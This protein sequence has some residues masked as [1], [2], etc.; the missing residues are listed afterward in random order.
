MKFKLDKLCE[1]LHIYSVKVLVY[2]CLVLF[3]V[4][5]LSNFFI[6]T[7]FSETYAE[8]SLFRADN[9]VIISAL[10]AVT[11]FLFLVIDNKFS[12]SKLKVW[13]LLFL[14]MVF[15]LLVS[16]IWVKIA[17]STP[18][19]D[20]LFVSMIASD[21]LKGDYTALN[22]GNYLY[23][24]PFQ[25]GIVA[26]IELVYKIAGNGNYQAIQYLNA[27]A[28]CITFF[29]LYRIT[30]LIFGEKI[31]KVILMLLFGCFCAM[32]FCTYVYGNLFGLAF[33]SLALWMELAYLESNKSKY[34]IMSIIFISIG[35]I[36]KNN[37]SIVLIAMVILLIINFLKKKD[38]L[39]IIFAVLMISST[40]ATSNALKTYYSNRAHV[41]VNEGIPMVTFVAMGLQDGWFGKG[42]YNKYTVDTYKLAKYNEKETTKI[43]NEK[44][45]EQ[46]SYYLKNP[47]IGL[48]FFAEKSTL[49]W[50]EPTYM[51]IWE[52][53][54]ANNHNHELSNFTN[55][56]YVGFW[57]NLIVGFMNFYQSF[58]WICAAFYIILK[59]K[60]LNENQ[61]LLGLIII[62]GFLFHIMWEAKSQYIIQYF[63]FAIP[64][65][66]AGFIEIL[67]KS[68]EYLQKRYEISKIRSQR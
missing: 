27:I 25:L 52:S 50:T 46:L 66:A 8:W 63:I 39:Y 60:V 59:R 57:H 68:K 62:G 22:A 24:Y 64:Y 11:I 38:V 10:F 41:K 61:M 12:I 23:N 42:T 28:V 33:T 40:M 26:F 47:I 55:S 44:I 67:D 21:F 58:I 18:I 30:K 34:I 29:S 7:Y 5:A 17:H 9:I 54:C 49:Q 13:K 51:S 53:N 20:R 16:V 15:T 2:I 3:S 65:G 45:K 32:F 35:M 1:R 14:L 31:S 6:S 48:E 37:Y 4:L 43:G 56:M 19:A 36:L